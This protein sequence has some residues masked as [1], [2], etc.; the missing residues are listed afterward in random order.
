[1][2]NIKTLIIYEYNIQYYI[3]WQYPIYVYSTYVT[4]MYTYA[5]MSLILLGARFSFGLAYLSQ[6]MKDD[7]DNRVQ[8]Y[9]FVN[10][11]HI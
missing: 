6:N 8:Q 4:V 5:Y 9:S 3:I 11:K 7:V 10:S 2:I 1:M